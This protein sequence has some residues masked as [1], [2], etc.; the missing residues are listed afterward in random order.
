MHVETWVGGCR[1]LILRISQEQEIKGRCAVSG[2]PPQT[3][4]V[5]P[6]LPGPG[7]D[8]RM[9]MV[10][11]V[12]TKTE[13]SGVW[14]FQNAGGSVGEVGTSVAY[15]RGGWGT[16]RIVPHSMGG[17][18][19]FLVFLFVRVRAGPAIGPHTGGRCWPL[20]AGV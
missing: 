14:F 11:M 16:E 4:C 3:P 13:N 6:V 8:T 15:G 19:W 1:S 10:W 7:S 20:L 9:K 2:F 18:R 17:S 12:M 5:T